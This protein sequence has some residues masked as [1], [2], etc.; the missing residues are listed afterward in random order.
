MPMRVCFVAAEYASLAKSGGLADVATALCRYLHAQGLELKVFL[1][2]YQRI[3]RLGLGER[4]VP[5]LEELTLALG[6]HRYSYSVRTVRDPGSSLQLNLI[7]C[8]ALFEREEI[9]GEGLDEHLRFLF[10]TRAAIEVCQKL[11][12]RPEILHCNDWHTAVAPL[13]LKSVYAWDRLFALTRTVLTLHN[14]GYQGQL[15]ASA[16]GD[17]GIAGHEQLLHQDDLRAG[18]VNLL[19]HGILYADLLTTVSPSYAREIQTPEYGMGLDGDLVRR[20]DRLVGI[21]NGVDYRE[22]NPAADPFGTPPFTATTLAGKRAAKERL[23][24]RLGL[25]GDDA[26]LIGLVSRLV[27]QKGIDLLT[28][29]LPELLAHQDIRLVALGTGERAIEEFLA[30]LSRRHPS[31]VAFHRGYSD[32]LAHWIEAASDMFLMPSRYE[33][34]GLNQ[35]YSLRYGTVPIVRRTGGLADSV[36]PWPDL[37]GTGIAFEHATAEGVRWALETALGLYRDPNA[38]TA[39]IRNGMA[40]DFSWERQ[41]ARY[42]EEY[43]R[44][45]G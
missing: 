18:R 4:P 3:R 13:Y 37:K 26:P 30:G 5:G 42:L 8:P 22:W 33:P 17:L 7:D 11:G 25:A 12:F 6:P 35:M 1:P 9:Y 16:V 39:L 23:L 20:R 19:R 29:V 41:A 32:E 38:W 34:C 45:V 27:W 43:R 36:R 31:R 15:P 28:E 10:F 24:A 21:L 2:A 44:L 14:L 40:E